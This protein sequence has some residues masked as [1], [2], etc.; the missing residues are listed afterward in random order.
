MSKARITFQSLQQDS[1]D[2]GTF[3]KSDAHVVSVIRFSMDVDEKHFDNLS[4]EVRQPYGTDFESEPLE[5]SKVIGDY[6]GP[7]NH[8]KFAELCES[9]YRNLVGSSGRAIHIGGG[10]GMRM[11]D[12]LFQ[13]TQE[14]E[15][16]IPDEQGGAW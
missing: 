8:A 2:Y 3:E 11:R 6:R 14:A 4:V 5:V 15:L 13:V 10:G 16:E 12:N 9:Y 1:Q 7:W